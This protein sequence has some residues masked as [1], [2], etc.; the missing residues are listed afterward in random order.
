MAGGD[1]FWS[2]LRDISENWACVSCRDVS[3][4]PDCKIRVCA[5]KKGV[6]MCAL[7]ESYPCKL[8]D[9]FDEGYP[10]LISDNALLRDVGWDAWAK[11]Q[12]ERR[13]CG[14]TYSD[15]KKAENI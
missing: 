10:C 2:F 12:D 14:F 5:Q 13:A 4:N 8:I 6:E 1:G 7:C 3:G 11:L 9:N 15:G